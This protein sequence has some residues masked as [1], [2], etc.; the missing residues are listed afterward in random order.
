MHDALLIVSLTFCNHAGAGPVPVTGDEAAL[1]SWSEALAAADE[2]LPESGSVAF[3]CSEVTT[4]TRP[5]GSVNVSREVAAGT[6]VWSGR[7]SRWDY[8]SDSAGTGA[9]GGDRPVS[10]RERR[11]F[12]W[13]PGRYITWFVDSAAIRVGPTDPNHTG[14]EGVLE[15]RPQDGWFRPS[16]RAN[17]TWGEV[18]DARDPIPNVREIEAERDGTTMTARLR[19]LGRD[20]VY[21]IT[22]D[23]T[24]GTITSAAVSP[25]PEEGLFSRWNAVWAKTDGPDAAVYP[26]EISRTSV[27]RPGNGVTA[28]EEWRLE[29]TD[30]KPDVPLKADVFTLE[31]LAA[32]PDTEVQYH[33]RNGRLVQAGPLAAPRSAD[34]AA[35]SVI[36][37]LA[38][39][40]AGGTLAGGDDDPA[41]DG[42]GN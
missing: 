28:T 42:D 5:D 27:H 30:F 11:V 37:R 39:Q 15:A 8:K 26:R 24:D 33:D 38:G 40:N 17:R 36:D 25:E 9:A 29:I 1:T 32:P 19:Y 10:P 21:T 13:T 6:V 22:G 4:T 16:H 20:H 12:V 41:D 2:N 14:P 23:L 31:G 3:R 35:D 18:L 7:N 34:E